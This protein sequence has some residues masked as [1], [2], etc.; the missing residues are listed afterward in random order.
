[1]YSRYALRDVNFCANFQIPDLHS[2]KAKKLQENI[3]KWN[4]EYESFD[5]EDFLE[6]KLDK[7]DPILVD[8]SQSSD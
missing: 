4:V 3:K 8:F 6:Q 5:F 1:M 2:E 7:K